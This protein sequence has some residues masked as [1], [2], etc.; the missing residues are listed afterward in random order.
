MINS[1]YGLDNVNFSTIGSS[2]SRLSST[3]NIFSK[4]IEESIKKID[5][6]QKAADNKLVSFIKGDENEVHNLM[7]AMEEAKLSMQTAIEVR[8]KLI[9]AYKELSSIQI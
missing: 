6:Y 7:I 1:I 3:T 5:G 9:E 8:N 2:R 4:M